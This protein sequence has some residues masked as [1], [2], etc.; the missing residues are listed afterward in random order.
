MEEGEKGGKGGRG[1]RR[2][3]PHPN[4]IS[5]VWAKDWINI[6][7]KWKQNIIHLVSLKTLYGALTW[8]HRLNSVLTVT[9]V[10][11]FFKWRPVLPRV[12][13]STTHLIPIVRLRDGKSCSRHPKSIICSKQRYFKI[14]HKVV[15]I[16]NQEHPAAS[17][18][19]SR[20]RN[21]ENKLQ[22]YLAN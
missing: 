3:E 17:R 14:F 20:K 19:G 6:L 15:K 1:E 10:L 7:L 5:C 4:P 16:Q 8:W 9:E 2:Q 13:K 18:Y 22:G 12:L 11:N 21:W